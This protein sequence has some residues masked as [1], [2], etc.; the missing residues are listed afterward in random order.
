MMAVPALEGPA[1]REQKRLIVT[2]GP[3]DSPRDIPP[4]KRAF[5]ANER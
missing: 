1:D 3:P 4:D 5:E 2:L